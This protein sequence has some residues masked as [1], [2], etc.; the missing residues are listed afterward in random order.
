MN[1]KPT[2]GWLYLLI[3]LCLLFSGVMAYRLWLKLDAQQ[4]SAQAY[5]ALSGAAVHAG[6]TQFPD[7]TATPVPSEAAPTYEPEEEDQSDTIFLIEHDVI[8]MADLLTGEPG[9]SPAATPSPTPS[10]TP[11]AAPG[12]GWV[13]LTPT[14]EGMTPAPA[15]PTPA[16]T[17]SPA[18]TATPRPAAAATEEPRYSRPVLVEDVRFTVDFPYLQT[19]NE[20]VRAWILQEGTPI[21]YPVLQAKNNDYYLDHMFNRR[22]NQDGAIFMDSGNN[23]FFIDANTYIYGHHTKTDA[24]FTSLTQYRDQAYYEQHPQL[25]LLTPY[26]DYAIDLFAVRVAMADDETSWRVKQFL[27][28]SEF[29]AYLADLMADSLITPMAESMPE[30]GD[31]WL[32]LVTCTNDHAGE[33]YVVYGR[34]R[35]I[36]YASDEGVAIT[37]MQMDQQQT[38]TARQYVP[39]RGEMIVYAQNDPLWAGL[40]YE[41]AGTNRRRTFGPGGCGPTSVA[42]AVVNLVPKERIADLFGYAKSSL[43]YTFCQDSVNQYYCNKQHAQYQVQTP[44][45]YLRYYPLV[46]ANF[47]TGNNY[48]G[49]VTRGSGTGTSLAFLKKIAY[50]YKLDLAVTQSNEEAIAAVENGALAVASLGSSN[51]FTGGGH[52]VVLASADADFLYY[53]DPYRKEGYSDTDRR[54]ILTQIAPGVVRVPRDQI[55]AT[56][57]STY[58]LLKA[59]A[60]TASPEP[61]AVQ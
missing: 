44:D 7:A 32:V 30:W 13:V 17:A 29:T 55:R 61:P 39:G 43:G 11:S 1:R 40:R 18:P 26:S 27:R 14:P 9:E 34:M 49:Q 48:W 53:L 60:L 50:L 3:L 37:K 47:A 28:K 6:L 12:E 36:V 33:R 2:Y 54:G 35:P 22:I 31:Q 56:G 5:Q 46:M 23:A 59:T 58:Y 25:T 21:N 19:L 38:L 51:P 24:M 15:T 41:A 16:P 45:E 57:A 10:P 20:D 4:E 52:Y 8:S 42:M